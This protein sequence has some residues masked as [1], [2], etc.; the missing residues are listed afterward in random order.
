MTDQN[1]KWEKQTFKI[2]DDVDLKSLARPG[3]NLFIADRGAVAFSYPQEWV[4]LPTKDS[5]KLHDRQPPDDDCVMGVSVMRLPPVKGG[6]GGLP[7]E[8]LVREMMKND[9]RGASP[10]GEVRNEKRPDLELSWGEL[11]FIDPVEIRTARSRCC[12]ARANL[13][14]PLITMDFWESD[15]ERFGPAWDEVLRTLRVG[16][17]L[18]PPGGRGGAG[19]N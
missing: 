19:M 7:L 15:L 11:S 10:L 2:P 14:Q 4:I 1:P 8:K 3:Y 6:W 9:K 16:L 5:I 12:L 18:V 13:V 17:E